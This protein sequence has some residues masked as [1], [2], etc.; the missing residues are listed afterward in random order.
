[1]SLFVIAL[2][3]NALE[4]KVKD[5]STMYKKLRSVLK[6]TTTHLCNV[7]EDGHEVV[8][9]HG[10]GP[11]IGNILLMNEASKSYIPFDICSA[12]SQG[13]IGYPLA[14]ELQSEILRRGIH[15]R[16]IAVLTQSL[17]DKNDPAFKSPSKPIGPFYSKEEA[18][19]LEKE[20]G[21][22]IMED[23]N[24]GYRRCVASP[25]PKKI[26]EMSLIRSLVK[27]GHVV[28]C[29]GGGGIPVVENNQELTGVDA[30]IDKDFASARL[31]DELKADKLIILTAVDQVALNFGKVNQKF[32]DKVNV[33]DLKNFIHEGH[34]HKGSMLPKI[35][36]AL[37]FLQDSTDR[38]S[39]V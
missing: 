25:R 21:Y 24:R 23:S 19:N 15:K 35:N 34:F 7:I 38:K 4:P 39:V 3:G 1:M 22:S 28:I 18:Q 6:E 5:P 20:L 10:N 2:G 11:Q 31:A 17:V 33:N 16:V 8:V 9:T 13:M 30:V 27:D 37:D 32:L 26:V 29:A 14:Q 12:M 36:A